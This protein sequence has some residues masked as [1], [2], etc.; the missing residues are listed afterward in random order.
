MDKH[1]EFMSHKPPTFSNSSDPLQAD[2]SLKSMD[3]ILNIAQCSD[4]KKVLYASGC[5]TGP[6]ADWWDA[7]CD[8]HAAAN[9]ITWAEFS[10]QFRNYH[11]PASLMKIK[12]EFLSLK[13]GGMSVRD[14]FIQLSW[15]APGEV[16]DDEKKQELFLKVWS[17]HYNTNW[18][19]THSRP[20]R[21]YWT[22]L[23]LWKTRELS[24]EKKGKLLTRDKL[25]VVPVPV[26]LHLKA[27]L[28]VVVLGNKLSRPK[29]L[30]N[31]A[32]QWDLLLLIPPQTGQVS[33]VDRL[34]T[35]P[36]TVPTGLSIP[37]QLQWSKV[38]PRQ[39]RVSPY[40][41][42]GVKST[43]WKQK[44][45]LVNLKTKKRCR[46]KVKKPMK[47]SMSSKIRVYKNIHKYKYIFK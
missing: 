36:T 47:K 31:Q 37:L 17:G 3:K 30:L 22:K 33:S 41:S 14:K 19:H 16:D 21:D 10:T 2:D 18:Y 9:T 5:L 28:P 43:T 32:P 13:Q 38:R 8:A 24:L 27:H 45:N 23:L 7:Y 42:I 1:R 29:L 15:Y 34:D 4:R 44:L 46:L 11:I 25:E 26:I 40:M 6:A 35:M 12:K 39:A 20:S